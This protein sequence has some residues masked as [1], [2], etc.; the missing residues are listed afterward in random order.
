VARVKSA[1]EVLALYRDRVSDR[2]PISEAQRKL[3]SVYN[4]DVVFPLPEMGTTASTASVANLIAQGCDQYARR[5]ASMLPNLDVP[6]L[7]EAT[8]ASK[9]RAV[10]RKAVLTGWHEMAKLKARIL[11]RGGRHYYGYGGAAIQV[12]PN[13][14]GD[15]PKWRLRDFIETFPAPGEPDEACPADVIHHFTRPLSWLME[16]YEDRLALLIRRKDAKP[17][18]LFSILEY[19]SA[20]QHCL[21][22]VGQAEDSNW[23]TYGGAKAVMLEDEE[24]RIGR[25]FTVLP[26]RITLDKP[27]G[28]FDQ[29]IGMY[30][31]RA[32]L[33]E[34]QVIAMRRAIWPRNWL[35]A[36]D[37]QTPVI[38][39]EPDPDEGRPGLL[40][41]GVLEREQLDPSYQ[42]TDLLNR[43]E[44]N[45]R[46][47]AGILAEF[48]GVGSTNVRTGRRGGQ[49]MGAAMDFTLAEA[50]EAFEEAIY[51]LDCIGIE[52]DKA[53]HNHPKTV[54]VN[55]RGL[56]AKVDYT[57]TELWETHNHSV[58]FP[59]LGLD[60]ADAT[61]VNGQKVGMGTMSK[62][63][64]MHRDPDIADAEAEKRRLDMEAIESIFQNAFAAQ[65]QNPE[66]PWQFPHV[67]R[68]AKMLAEG[69]PWYE[70]VSDLQREIQEEQASVA[71]PP[72]PGMMPPESM[73]GLAMPGQ[74]VE[75]P[76]AIPEQPTSMD[77]LTGLLQSL[78]MGAA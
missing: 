42:A 20:A 3:R 9:R 14:G 67:A 66:G 36:N 16:R 15:C 35:I 21:V 2:H 37:N 50:Q 38:I 73:P 46:E 19:Q 48:G 12:A 6:P 13:Y 29:V 72:A 61:V 56:K 11:G 55:A 58:E 43:L 39:S 28:H 18:T 30:L 60:A 76:P 62:I 17:D 44:S 57:P 59:S 8:E 4:A 64:F 65:A 45:E 24:N 69:K 32:E 68:F 49:V 54:Y 78:Q 75:V 52:V 77:N 31:T 71:Q 1:E 23:Q 7:T 70:A 10:D 41:G 40:K 22:L 34:M 26:A 25:C 51:E 53:Y 63:T 74:G 27:Q 5:T 47:G 33:M